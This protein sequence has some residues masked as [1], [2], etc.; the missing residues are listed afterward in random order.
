[1]VH[2]RAD[3]VSVD[4]RDA[5][6]PA[7]L[8]ALAKEAGAELIGE[9]RSGETLT[10]AFEDVPIAE[11]LERLVGAQNF[12]LKYEEGGRL[13]AIELRGGQEAG[14]RPGAP[15]DDPAAGDAT[16]PKWMAFYKAFDRRDLVPVPGN[17]RKAL[18]RDEAG[19]DYLGNSAIA[20]ADPRVRRE[21]VRAIMRTLDADPDMKAQVL[22]ALS[23]MSPEELAAFARKS[24]FYRAEDLVRNV[25]RETTDPDVRSRAREVLHELRRHPFKGTYHD[26]H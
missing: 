4:L 11:A 2:Y 13:R 6:L 9:P 26:L 12:T 5:A 1:V 8:A 20:A 25:M 14:R 16:P 15:A 10:L 18:G 19:W 21:T 24:A 22:G 3:K 17:L 23:A 7:V